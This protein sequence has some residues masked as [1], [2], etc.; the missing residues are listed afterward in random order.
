MNFIEK[1]TKSK[2]YIGQ[3]I[4][5]EIAISSNRDEVII[6]QYPFSVMYLVEDKIGG[7]LEIKKEL[8][9]RTSYTNA[10]IIFIDTLHEILQ[11]KVEL[12]LESNIEV[13]YHHWNSPCGLHAR[14]SMKIATF[15][16]DSNSDGTIEKISI[17][18]I[19]NRY[20]SYYNDSIT[21]CKKGIEIMAKGVCHNELVRII[22]WGTSIEQSRG[23]IKDIVNKEMEVF[24]KGYYSDEIYEK[25]NTEAYCNKE[26][27]PHKK[28]IKTFGDFSTLPNFEGVISFNNNKYY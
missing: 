9:C 21:D 15:F 11:V 10:T 18:N 23:F 1:V 13:Y 6:N 3:S 19:N 8:L 17:H 25:V 5:N 26:I 12:P 24:N 14:P 22:I 4:G 2:L 16:N 28:G 20:S 27:N 7:L